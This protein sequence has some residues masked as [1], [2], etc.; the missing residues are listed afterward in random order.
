MPRAASV[1]LVAMLLGSAGARCTT[2]VQGADDRQVTVTDLDGRAV[3]PLTAV[4]GP[5]RG[6][7]FVFTR[8]DCPIATGTHRISSASSSG[9]RPPRSRS[10]W[11]SWIRPRVPTLS[12]STCR[13]SATPGAPCSTPTRAGAG[14]R[15]DDRARSGRV[16]TR[17]PVATTRD[18]GRSTTA[19]DRPD[20]CVRL[21]PPMI[22]RTSSASCAGRVPS[23]GARLRPWDA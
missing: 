2:A 11:Y 3:Q 22:S 7:V 10:G 20:R 18:R 4:T 21:P 16:C 5:L 12:A 8:S 23:S 9:P 19:I 6:A 17:C 14:R 15:R 1:M 13:R